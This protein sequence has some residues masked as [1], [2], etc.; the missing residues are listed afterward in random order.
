MLKTVGAEKDSGE[1]MIDR[2]S[3]Q[4]ANL[5]EKY[6]QKAGDTETEYLLRNCFTGENKILDGM[7]SF[8]FWGVN[9]LLHHERDLPDKTHLIISRIAHWAG[10]INVMEK[11]ERASTST[12]STKIYIYYCYKNCLQIKHKHADEN[13]P[14]SAEMN[15][16]VL[17]PLLRGTPTVL[18]YC[19]VGRQDKVGGNVV[20]SDALHGP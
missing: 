19:L 6:G 18:R 12:Q 13:T 10:E 20:H 15:L 3:P 1:N 4:L 11:G 17:R 2:N 16:N 7:A 5:Q 8:G 14:T 9:V